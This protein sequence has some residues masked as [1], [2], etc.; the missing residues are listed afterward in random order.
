[1]ST[2]SNAASS[3]SPDLVGRALDRNGLAGG[4]LRGEKAQLADGKLP[5]EEDLD[6]RP[7][8]DAGGADDRDGESLACHVVH[9]SA[10]TVAG[11]A[12]REYISE[13]GWFRWRER[14][15]RCKNSSA[16]R[17]LRSRRPMDDVPHEGSTVAFRAQIEDFT[18]LYERTYQPV[19]RT[20]LG[21]CGDAALAADLTQD[22][23]VAAYRNRA[24][25]RGDVPVD[26][27]LHR[28]A[29]NAA[30]AGLR[31]R[32]VRWAEPL[33]TAIHDRSSAPP[34]EGPDADLQRALL[35]LQPQARAAVVLR[36]YLDLDYA[37]IA[38]VLGTT[39]GNVGSLLSRSLDRM[40]RELTTEVP[41]PSLVTASTEEVRDGR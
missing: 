23:Y 16:D 36:Y 13:V 32:R 21:I 28:I 40:R 5:F 12:P 41:S 37:S 14:G 6:H 7:P 4:S 29:V 25:F 9:G 34:D 39:S 22:A 17:V 2:P 1:M 30:L 11:R 10:V 31:R 19:Y 15:G 20:V 18:A 27:W 26:A 38:T 24:T 8:D 3:A 35:Q 33:D